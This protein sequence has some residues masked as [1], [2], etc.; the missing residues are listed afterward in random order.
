MQCGV[1]TRNHVQMFL[2]SIVTIFNTKEWNSN[3]ILI[4]LMTIRLA[5]LTD[6]DRV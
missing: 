3:E 4:A 5:D 2:F 1:G 6:N